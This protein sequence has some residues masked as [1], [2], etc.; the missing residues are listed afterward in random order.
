MMKLFIL[1]KKRI[2][3]ITAS[4]LCVGG[5]IT[6]AVITMREDDSV[7]A[8]KASDIYTEM[9]KRQLGDSE[10]Y[11]AEEVAGF[12][13]TDPKSIVQSA[14]PKTK[15]E[16]NPAPPQTTAPAPAPTPSAEQTPPPAETPV[17]ANVRI[18]NRAKEWT[19]VNNAT[20][21]DVDMEELEKKPLPFEREKGKPAVLIVHTHT[22]EAFCE[23]DGCRSTDE[24]NN[25]I[26]VGKRVCELFNAAGIETIHD[27]TVHDYPSY[28]GAYGR[29]LTTV[30]NMLE[31]YP[32]IRVVLDLHRDSLELDDGTVLKLLCDVDGKNAAQ[33]M[34]VVGTDSMGLY[35]PYW[36]DNMIFAA[37]IQKR[38]QEMYPGLMRP[39]N[40]RTERFN[41]HTTRASL[42]LEI[43]GNG[44]TMD[45][46]VRAAEAVTKVMIDVM[47]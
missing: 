17:P 30:T 9:V 1:T 28:V 23:I 41:Q 19:V 38:A 39:L 44:N 14:I 11:S 31:K 2:I 8:F 7:A 47:K 33:V 45:E 32:S 37:K 36:R 12:N 21:Y 26:N 10:V 3:A 46:A 27:C 25:M 20:K 6:G 22:T 13:V 29:S 18:E 4:V 42:I 15:P 16:D 24:E 40:L 43:G 34:T 5:I 35:H